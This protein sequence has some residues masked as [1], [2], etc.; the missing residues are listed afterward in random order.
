MF[1]PLRLHKYDEAGNTQV[2]VA[3]HDDSEDGWQQVQVSDWTGAWDLS[4]PGTLVFEVE[5]YWAPEL[6]DDGNLRLDVTC[7]DEARTFIL[8][9]ETLQP[10]EEIASP[11]TVPAS[12][13]EVRSDYV[14]QPAGNERG[15]EMQVNL[16][17]DSGAAGSF[18]ARDLL[19][20]PDETRRDLLR[21]ESLGEK[22][23]PAASLLACRAAPRGR[24]P[25]HQGRLQGRGLEDIPQPRLQE[26]GRLRELR[27]A[28]AAP[29]GLSPTEGPELLTALSRRP[30]AAART[31]R[32]AAA[33]G[34]LS[35]SAWALL[36]RQ[37]GQRRLRVRAGGRPGRRPPA[38]RS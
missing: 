3:R 8:D 37:P 11:P 13:T 25:R 9:G 35:S 26:P 34:C 7:Q 17:D 14:H 33:E 18:H 31:C 24:R 21:W 20:A 19:P 6:T 2:Y 10:I 22:P 29:A 12:V 30:S 15:T 4:Q 28:G 27:A 5:V 23:G 38:G 1:R 16:N 36:D 32:G